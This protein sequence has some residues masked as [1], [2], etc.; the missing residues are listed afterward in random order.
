[1][2]QGPVFP[3][4]RI[5]GKES[6]AGYKATR[7]LFVMRLG[8]LSTTKW[9]ERARSHF[10]TPITAERG[11]LADLL[12]ASKGLLFFTENLAQLL[13]ELL[14]RET[15]G[16]APDEEHRVLHR[17]VR[18][19]AEVPCIEALEE[20]LAKHGKPEIFNTDSQRI[21]ASFRAA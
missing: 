20:A 13:R 18:D 17:R 7:P 8:R 12:V 10:S 15:T 1:M 3:R 16:V 21:N 11:G 4:G 19:A 6:P 5:A 2:P 9:S 14:R